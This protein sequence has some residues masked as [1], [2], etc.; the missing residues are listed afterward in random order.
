DAAGCER[1]ICRCTFVTRT[2]GD[3]V[4]RLKRILRALELGAHHAHLYE[5]V[6]QRGAR[7]LGAVLALEAEPDEILGQRVLAASQGDC[8]LR[9]PR[10]RMPVARLEQA[11][12]LLE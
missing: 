2:H 3:R 6:E 8:R 7:R 10:E 5:Q 12:G 9:A 1:G 11:L 4:E